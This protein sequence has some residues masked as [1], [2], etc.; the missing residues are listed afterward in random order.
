[1]SLLKDR[2]EPGEGGIPITDLTLNDFHMDLS[3]YIKGHENQLDRIPSGAYAVAI[4]DDSL[5]G[6]FFPG[7]IFCLKNEGAQTW[8]SRIPDSMMTWSKPM[9]C[10]FLNMPALSM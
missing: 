9:R 1:M 10:R 8:Y 4:I 3:D 5:K 6:E 7:V 2:S